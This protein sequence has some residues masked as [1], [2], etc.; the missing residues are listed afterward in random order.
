MLFIP[1]NLLNL[2]LSALQALG[3]LF[4]VS[5]ASFN[6]SASFFHDSASFFIIIL[7]YEMCKFTN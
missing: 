7:S 1:A 5:S 6:D 3:I 2:S 4:L